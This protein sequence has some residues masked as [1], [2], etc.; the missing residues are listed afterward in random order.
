MII[1]S[2]WDGSV[3]M[4]SV[5]LQMVDQIYVYIYNNNTILYF[6]K[7]QTKLIKCDKM[8]AIDGRHMTIYFTILAT[9]LEVQNFE[10]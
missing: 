1:C 4:S 8:L 3:T 10:K 2:F 5:N 9:F 6:N 7:Y